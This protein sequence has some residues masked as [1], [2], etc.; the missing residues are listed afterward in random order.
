MT[1]VFVRRCRLKLRH[2]CIFVVVGCS[3]VR[4]SRLV[5]A[6]AVLDFYQYNNIYAEKV[7]SNARSL[8]LLQRGS[9]SVIRS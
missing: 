3:R 7:I 5:I 1:V 9:F 4:V 2:Y 8:F 6:P